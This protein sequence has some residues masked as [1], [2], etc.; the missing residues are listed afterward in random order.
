MDRKEPFVSMVHHFFLEECTIAGL[1]GLGP[2]RK[3]DFPMATLRYPCIFGSAAARRDGSCKEQDRFS[4]EPSSKALSFLKEEEG[5][6][7][8]FMLSAQL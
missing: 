6:L 7:V 3:E 4:R 2:R 8:D 5:E 1:T